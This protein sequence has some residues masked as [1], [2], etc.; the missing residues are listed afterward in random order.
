MRHGVASASVTSGTQEVANTQMFAV[1]SRPPIPWHTP[2]P[3]PFRTW[4]GTPK[5]SDAH[6]F[7]KYGHGSRS[8][9]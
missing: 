7:E 5:P 1:L 8:S 3:R 4:L 6:S 2:Q 9:E